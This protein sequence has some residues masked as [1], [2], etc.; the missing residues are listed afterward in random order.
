M[1]KEEKPEGEPQEQNAEKPENPES[2][3]DEEREEGREQDDYRAKLNAQNRFLEKEGYEFKDGKWAKKP[4]PKPDKNPEQGP[5]AEQGLS[6]KEMYALID[7]KVHVEDFD[8]VK[9]AAK[10]IGKNVIEALRDPTVQAILEKRTE[11]R[12]SAQAAN[13]RNVRPS[14]KTP[15]DAEIVAEAS[16]G[17][18]PAKGSQEAEQLF[19]ARR[20]GKPK[21]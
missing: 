9:K 14:T 19:W 11:H 15:T 21:Q 20:G 18:I 13:T 4:Q 8:E 2:S 16:K 1:E 6:D 3:N 12:K 10:I 17:N 7:A 5:Q